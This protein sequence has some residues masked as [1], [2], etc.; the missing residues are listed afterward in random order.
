MRERLARLHPEV[1][2]GEAERG[3][4]LAANPEAQRRTVRDL[5][6]ALAP[7]RRQVAALAGQITRLQNRLRHTPARVARTSLE[8][9]AQRAILQHDRRHLVLAI[10]VAAYDAER[11]LAQRFN[12][13]YR[14]AKD[15]L[16]MTAALFQQ[17]GTLHL[18][19]G[20][21]HVRIVPPADSRAREAFTALCADLNARKLRW[22]NTHSRLHFEPALNRTPPSAGEVFIEL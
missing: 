15:Y 4:A 18:A 16:T 6:I 5:K 21:L 13:T 1:A 19:D 10:K 17:P 8:P 9:R 22:L 14:Q 2:A 3:R 7:V 11:C 20:V 12:Q